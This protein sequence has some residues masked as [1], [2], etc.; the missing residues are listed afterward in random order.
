MVGV[1]VQATLP[2]PGI[3]SASYLD[4]L[5]RFTH[6]SSAAEFAQRQGTIAR[7]NV[8]LLVDWGLVLELGGW[9]ATWLACWLECIC[10]DVYLI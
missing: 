8:R 3:G 6:D 7:K 4:E 1:A 10:G 2:V 5:D 9:Q